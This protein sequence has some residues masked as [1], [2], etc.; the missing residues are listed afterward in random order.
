MEDQVG[1]GECGKEMDTELGSSEAEDEGRVKV[2]LSIRFVSSLLAL[3]LPSLT[4]I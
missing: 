1:R 3:H 2:I 4:G